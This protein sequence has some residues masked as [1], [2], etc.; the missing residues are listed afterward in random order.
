MCKHLIHPA[1]LALQVETGTEVQHKKE[2]SMVWRSS[3]P[4]LLHSKSSLRYIRAILIKPK[5]KRKILGVSLLN[6]ILV[7]G[8]RTLGPTT[9]FKKKKIQ[10]FPQRSRY[11]HLSLPHCCSSDFLH[12]IT[13]HTLEVSAHKS[14]SQWDFLGP[15]YFFFL[16]NFIFY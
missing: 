7:V 16:A 5:C 8:K 4:A 14:L 11:C 2:A 15:I 1:N 3:K 12:Q 6:N 10:V 9:G 13:P